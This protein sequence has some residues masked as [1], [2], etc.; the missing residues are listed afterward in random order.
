MAAQSKTF[1]TRETLINGCTMRT[2]LREQLGGSASAALIDSRHIAACTADAE[3]A[4]RWGVSEELIFPFWEWVG[5]R[6]SVTSSVGQLPIALAFGP[7]VFDEFLDGARD[8][9]RH[10][11]EAPLEQNLPVLMGLLGVWNLNFLNHTARAIFPYCEALWR[12]PA[13]VQQVEMESNGKRV[14]ADGQLLDYHAA[15]VRRTRSRAA[16][17]VRKWP[18]RAVRRV[19]AD[20]PRLACSLGRR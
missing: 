4:L 3:A 2:W 10:C 11:L 13:H 6:F 12:L 19:A 15:E 9:D 7:A 5:G 1:R 8:I 14:S 18:R 17:A 16:A 20:R